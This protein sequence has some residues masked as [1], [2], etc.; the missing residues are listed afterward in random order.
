MPNLRQRTHR[1]LAPYSVERREASR[2]GLPVEIDAIVLAEEARL[3]IEREFESEGDREISV[4]GSESDEDTE[5]ERENE[6]EDSNDSDDSGDSGEKEGDEFDEFEH[7]ESYNSQ[8]RGVK[9]LAA[10]SSINEYVNHDVTVIPSDEEECCQKR[11]KLSLAL[12]TKT[13]LM[14]LTL[15]SFTDEILNRT[16]PNIASGDYHRYLQDVRSFLSSKAR[17]SDK[18]SLIRRLYGYI[19]KLTP[20]STEN[21]LCIHNCYKTI[22]L[23][24]KTAPVTFRPFEDYYRL[25]KANHSK[26]LK[27]LQLLRMLF[28]EFNGK[29]AAALGK[30]KG[31][32]QPNSRIA[33]QLEKMVFAVG[34][35][36]RVTVRKKEWNELCQSLSGLSACLSHATQ[37]MHDDTRACYLKWTYI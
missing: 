28:Y 4:L 33:E 36:V 20:L 31:D 26:K 17:D 37:I 3:E 5:D 1:Q 12:N 14:K 21:P 10:R 34:S 23:L 18:F 16:L 32:W 7:K 25:F 24:V 19:K 30:R 8:S 35:Y 6:L 13:F 9:S 27:D 29:L 22:I 15:Y 11:K 2:K